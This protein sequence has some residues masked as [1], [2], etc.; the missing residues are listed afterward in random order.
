[1]AN[2]LPL[3]LNVAHSPGFWHSNPFHDCPGWQRLPAMQALPFHVSFGWQAD[4]VLAGAD[5]LTQFPFFPADC[6]AGHGHGPSLQIL[7]RRSDSPGF[8]C[9]SLQAPFAQILRRRSGSAPLC[10][11][12]FSLVG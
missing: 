10:S 3:E 11:F 2:K 8:G 5:A 12:S 6:P 9:G 1:M 4:A 7:R